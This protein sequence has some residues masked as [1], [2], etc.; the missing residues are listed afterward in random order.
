MQVKQ[1]GYDTIPMLEARSLRL[2]A[3]QVRLLQWTAARDPYRD[4]RGGNPG[5]RRREQ[6][7]ETLERQ[8]L[9]RKTND[10]FWRVTMFG[11]EMLEKY[12]SRGDIRRTP[13]RRKAVG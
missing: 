13:S 4:R 2:G 9:I 5:K 11:K 3:L 12:I 7:L 6:Q 10:G 1:M 8:G